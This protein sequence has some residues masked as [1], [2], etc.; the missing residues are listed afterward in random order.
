MSILSDKTKQFYDTVSLE[1]RKKEGQYMTPFSMI[2]KS[3]ES[4]DIDKNEHILEPSFGT[5]QFIDIL[6]EKG[7]KNI[8][9]VEKD[10]E[11]FKLQKKNKKFINNDY[12]QTN[13]DCKFGLIIGNPPYFEFKPDDET[14][15]KFKD[16]ISG[17]PNMYSL[18]IKKGIDEL[19]ENGI[20]SFIIP[21]SL[22][23]SKYFEQ[24]RFY[25]YK[26]CNIERIHKQ[27]TNDFED[28]LQKTMI[29][30][31]KKRPTDEK[32]DN[33]FIVNIGD[34]IIFSEEYD[35]INQYIQN[36]KCIKDLDCSVKTGN[37]VWNQ[38]RDNNNEILT[39]DDK[40]T[41]LLVYPRNLVDGEIKIVKDDKKPQYMKKNDRFNVFEA[42]VIAINR[43]IGNGCITFKPVLIKKGTYYFENHINVIT[44][45]LIKLKL[46]MTSLKDEETVDFV[47]NIIG[48][49]QLSKTELETMVPIKCKEKIK[50]K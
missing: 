24:T 21:T 33:K 1:Q 17:R 20:L 44:G 19:K 31:I 3:F 47:K 6:S 9:G 45:T 41:I 34:T 2:Y 29:F 16:V 39:N 40:N 14:K 10:K 12:L 25:I 42:P 13:F 35:K 30:Q 28:A 8:Y 49:T 48:N 27:N 18:F 37:I 38:V 43:I 46:I 36:K 32:T 7:F 11:I 26:Y 23:S 5:G 4:I 15:K 22:L 50:K